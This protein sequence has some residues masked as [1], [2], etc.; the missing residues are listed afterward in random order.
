MRLRVN[1][2]R[3]VVDTACP[4][5]SGPIYVRRRLAGHPLARVR[6]P[7]IHIFQSMYNAWGIY[8]LARALITAE[9]GG[10]VVAFNAVL[11]GLIVVGWN[12]LE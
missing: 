7:Y 8:Y 2:G 3:P 11:A 10:L 4:G 1:L 6:L 5:A 9:I 12:S